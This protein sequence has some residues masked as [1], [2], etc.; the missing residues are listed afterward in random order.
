MIDRR[1]FAAAGVALLVALPATGHA[2]R[3]YR[4]GVLRPGS[5]PEPD[6]VQATALPT[7]L[8][9]LG[10]VEGRNLMLQTR[11]AE[12]D[13]QRLPALARELLDARVEVIVAV[14]S[15]ATRVARQ[16]SSSVPIV[17]FGNFDPIALGLVTDLARPGGNLT[18][19]L[20]A[21]DGTLA[22]K[23]LELLKTLVPQATRVALL[24]PDDEAAMRLQIEETRKAAVALGIAL[25]VVVVRGRQYERAFEQVV[26]EKP[27]ALLVGAHQYFVR[28][29]QPIIALAA[30]HRLPAMYEW[31][32]QVVDGGL[33]SYSTSLPEL[34][35]RVA[36]HIDR[37]VKGVP[38][39]DIPIEQPSRFGLVVNLATLR[40]LG[41]SL[42]PAMRLRVD[43]VIE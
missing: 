17:M 38:A 16:A 42:M 20:I 19:I 41:M 13:L 36:S 33:M 3:A 15:S 7:A 34:W 26:A 27:Q 10:Y 21:P 14:G 30:K 22:G 24:A 31:R 25:P 4:V 39:G 11:Y 12:N 2:Q 32:E 18:G 40:A 29:R 1:T 5:R 43:E 8:R 35:A 6:D 23:R 28:D 37:I 9:E